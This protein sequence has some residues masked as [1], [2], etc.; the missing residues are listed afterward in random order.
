LEKRFGGGYFMT[1]EEKDAAIGRL[2]LEYTEAKKAVAILKEEAH[3]T[4]KQFTELGQCLTN[5]PQYFSLDNEVLESPFSNQRKNFNS[6]V[7]QPDRIK[8][9]ADDLRKA[10]KDIERLAPQIKELGL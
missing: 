6:S 1:E 5:F 10:T 7:F 9:L 2:V 8:A 4:G 3:K